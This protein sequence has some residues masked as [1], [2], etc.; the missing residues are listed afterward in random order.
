[1]FPQLSLKRSKVRCSPF[2]ISKIII[3]NNKFKPDL[4]ELEGNNFQ[5]MFAMELKEIRDDIPIRTFMTTKTRKESLFM[6]LL[7]AFEQGQIRTPYG[8]ERS[9]TFTHKLEEELN[10][11][12][13]Q[14]KEL[15]TEKK[16]W[17][18]LRQII[19]YRIL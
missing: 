13:H 10:R 18:I 16:N 8:D 15:E 11:R 5:R 4:I 3:L 9:K 1:M 2:I 6:S 19:T 7:L 12:G 17:Q 14:F